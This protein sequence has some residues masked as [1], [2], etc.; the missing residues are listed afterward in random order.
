M[1]TSDSITKIAPALVKAQSAMSFAS[2]NSKNPHFKNTY[3]D[4]PA[5]ID[6]V[7]DALNENGIV[8]IQTPTESEDGRL[9]LVTRLLHTTGEWIEDT[10]VC[11][12]PK[13]DPQGFGSALTYLRRYSLS[14]ICG[15]YQ[16]DDDGEKAKVTEN[17]LFMNVAILNKCILEITL[18][19]D[20]ESLKTM[21][22]NAVKMVGN[23]QSALKSLELAK[24]K[25]KMELAN[26]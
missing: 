5:V 8:F 3:A 7:K 22:I 10:A 4:L 12:L 23:D 21:Y 15:L 19:K 14:A 24:D 9:H 26:D 13:A 6:A 16:E 18:A 1:K 2:K 17:N 11:P 25:R 20:N